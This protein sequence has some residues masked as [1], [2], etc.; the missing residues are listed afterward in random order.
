MIAK[1]ISSDAFFILTPSAILMRSATDIWPGG[2][3]SSSGELGHNVMDHPFRLGGKWSDG[4]YEDKYYFGRRPQDFIF[5]DSEILTVKSGI[6]SED[7]VT[8]GA[9]SRSVANRDVPKL[10]FGAPMKE[11]LTSSRTLECWIYCFRERFWP[12]HDKL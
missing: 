7:L 9:A 1:S 5:Q 10:N 8:K 3:G 12:Y 2:L 11:A 4:G 6:I